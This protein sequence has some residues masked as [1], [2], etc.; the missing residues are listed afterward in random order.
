VIAI[1]VI[2]FLLYRRKKEPE[3]EVTGASLTGPEW[4]K[5]DEEDLG[6]GWNKRYADG[7]RIEVPLL[8]QI[9][10]VLPTSRPPP[11]PG[12]TPSFT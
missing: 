1:V 4:G 3:K 7:P 6:V 11:Y 2:G 5:N 10:E 9:G 12:P 8:P